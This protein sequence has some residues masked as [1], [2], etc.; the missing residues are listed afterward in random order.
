MKA[1]LCVM[2]Y[3]FYICG[4]FLC[5]G[6]PRLVNMLPALQ[7]SSQLHLI[8]KLQWAVKKCVLK[9]QEVHCWYTRCVVV[10]PVIHLRILV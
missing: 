8:F 5:R 1:V 10:W 2:T 4:I 9:T 3:C 7:S 6:Y